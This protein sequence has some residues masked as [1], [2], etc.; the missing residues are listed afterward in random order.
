MDWL[1][2]AATD[3]PGAPAIVAE[4]RITT[5]EQLDAAADGVAGLVAA[6]GFADAPVGLAGVRSPETVA[7][8]WGIQRAGSTPALLDP[9][10]PPERQRRAAQAAGVR[11][12]WEPPEGGLGRLAKRRPPRERR[13]GFPDTAAA[14]VLF[15]S[16]TEGTPKPVTLRGGNVAASVVGSRDRLGNTP[17]DRWLA[18]LPFAHVGGLSILWRQA[19]QGA[20][21]VLAASADAT[22]PVSLASVVPTMLRRALRPGTLRGVRTLVGGGPVSIEALRAAIGSGIIALQT[23]GMTETASQVCT[24][25]PDRLVDELGTA[26]MPIA[27]AQVRIGSDGRI[28]VRGDMVVDAFTGPDGWL[29]TGDLGELDADGRLVVLGRADAVIVSGGENVHPEGVQA[30]LEGH[31]EV[32]AARV[33]GEADEEWGNRVI[34]EVVGDGVDPAALRSWAALRLHPADVPKEIRV[35]ESLATKL[36]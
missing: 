11:G 35:V 32:I 4:T 5:Y 7:A 28:A 9:R 23:Y 8:L 27:G 22:P 21:V 34:A 18:V 10:W 3:R 16:G 26:G 15:T 30:V 6:S 20:P 24:V 25:H 29:V 13:N 31:P 14:A 1:R 19:E 33:F 36:T 12:L 17:D 2:S